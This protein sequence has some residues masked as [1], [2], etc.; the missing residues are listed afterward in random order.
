[1]AGGSSCRWIRQKLNKKIEKQL[2]PSND[3]NDT[4]NENGRGFE[5]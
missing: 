2:D 1:M 5:L 4:K 3:D